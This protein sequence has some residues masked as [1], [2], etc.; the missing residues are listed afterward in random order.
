VPIRLDMITRVRLLRSP[1]AM[2]ISPLRHGERSAAIQ[3]RPLDCR[4]AF[5]SSQ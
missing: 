5:G 1:L 4:V 2:R 3:R